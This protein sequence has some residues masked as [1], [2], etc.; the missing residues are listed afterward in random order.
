VNPNA[1]CVVDDLVT[2]PTWTPCGVT[3]KGPVQI[4]ES[5]G[6]ELGPGFG[7]R[8]IELAPHWVS[9]W[10]STPTRSQ[11]RHRRAEFDAG[12]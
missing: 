4:H 5:G 9:S 6:E 10:A 11:H 3:V 1:A 7:P 2:D 12:R 8:W